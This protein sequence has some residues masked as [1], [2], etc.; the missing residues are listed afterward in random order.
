MKGIGNSR[1]GNF[2][3]KFAN[4]QKGLKIMD[5]SLYEHIF[6]KNIFW[7]ILAAESHQVVKITIPCRGHH[8]HHLKSDI[9]I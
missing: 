8:Q 7:H 4:R 5:F 1:F 2:Q 6:E 9:D 3:D